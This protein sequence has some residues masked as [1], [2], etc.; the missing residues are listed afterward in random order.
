MSNPQKGRSPISNDPNPSPAKDLKQLKQQCRAE[1]AD[2]DGSLS[3]KEIEH[4]IGH[5]VEVL[6]GHNLLPVTFYL[7]YRIER[8]ENTL[9]RMV[10]LWASE[11]LTEEDLEELA[12]I[13]EG[14]DA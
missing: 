6:E 4:A 8:L 1:I 3:R 9:S 2:M 7:L 11:S 14:S 12:A 13:V 5:G 10:D